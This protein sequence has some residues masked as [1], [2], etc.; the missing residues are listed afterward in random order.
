[1]SNSL[2]LIL[3]IFQIGAFGTKV[4]RRQHESL[5]II[6]IFLSSSRFSGYEKTES[7]V[8]IPESMKN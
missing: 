2:L 8:K 3:S 7:N 5:F 4:I 1:M 6:E